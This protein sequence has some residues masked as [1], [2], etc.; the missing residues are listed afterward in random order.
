MNV[1]L[2]AIN[3]MYQH[4]SLALRLLGAAVS[5]L[6]VRH[7]P[8]ELNIN[9]R[10]EA[11]LREIYETRPDV[12]GFSCYIWNIRQVLPLARDIK[13]LLP[14]LRIVLGGPEVGYT[15][16]EYLAANPQIDAI[17]CGEGECSY[18]L[19]LS[20]YLGGGH[21]EGIPG[22]CT[23]DAGPDVAFSEPAPLSAAPYRSAKSYDPGRIWYAE[24]SRGCPFSCGF[25]LS[26]V[27]PGVRGLEAEEAVSMLRWMA[28]HGAKLVKLVDRSFNYN[29]QRAIEIWKGLLGATGD[30][31]FHFEVEPNLLDARTLRFLSTVPRQKFQFEIGIQSTNPETL[32]HISRR[33]DRDHVGAM[34]QELHRFGN[35]P[36]HLDLIA[37]LPYEDYASFGSSFDETFGMKP[38]VLQLG[39]L[40]LLRGCALRRDAASY[41]IVHGE[42]AP[43]EVLGTD[44]LP[45]EELS[46]L[47]DIAKV[48]DMFFN[49]GRYPATLG[50]LL[51]HHAPFAAFEGIAA[52]LRKAGALQTPQSQA[53]RLQALLLAG[54]PLVP[55]QEAEHWK[56]AVRFDALMQDVLQW[57][58]ACGHLDQAENKLLRGQYPEYGK[59]RNVTVARFSF[60]V[61]AL[62]EERRFAPGETILCI[63]RK[64]SRYV[65][66]E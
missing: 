48:V 59:S 33:F 63:W 36:L 40:K 15:P 24:T 61:P 43:Y 34:L 12:L 17:V 65:V 66:L 55:R 57:P 26:S 11:M 37:G 56:D 25:C 52:S 41:G 2:V 21:G 22:V 30:C 46:R 19:L 13:K 16:Q 62:L 31:V 14:G 18:R 60:D 9:M 47:K 10:Q 45:Y 53:G 49:F 23:A 38:T 39:F 6:P 20:S 8:L 28:D 42:D 27:L 44:H 5:G 4:T 58:D 35:I 51:R 7:V 29:P 50:L 3:A 54:S 32:R 64:E 1:T